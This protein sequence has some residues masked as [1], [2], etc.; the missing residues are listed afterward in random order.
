MGMPIQDTVSFH[1]SLV[2]IPVDDFTGKPVT[3]SK[4]RVFIPGQKPP[5]VKKEG[6]YVFINLTE[7]EVALHCESGLYHPRTEEIRLGETEELCV[8]RIRLSPNASYPIPSGT[9][10]VTGTAV[11]GRRVRFRCTDG[12]YKLLYEYRCAGEGS[13]YISLYNPEHREFA[14]KTFLIQDRDKKHREYFT[15]AGTDEE[16]R[17]RLSEPL[18]HD[19]KKVGSIIFPIYEVCANERGDFFLPIG[20]SGLAEAAWLWETEGEKEIREIILKPGQINSLI[21]K[22]GV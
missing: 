14:G 3:G 18:Q 21:W 6:Y 8:F 2:V 13:S 20:N 17:C 4:V 11:P 9:T 5:V 19:Y 10:C 15:V 1:A 7:P 22:E 16:G 12:A